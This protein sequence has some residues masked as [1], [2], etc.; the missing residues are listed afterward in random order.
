MSV[1]GMLQW[2]RVSR[3]ERCFGGFGFMLLRKECF[4]FFHAEIPTS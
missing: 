3:Y 1:V 2:E 4:M